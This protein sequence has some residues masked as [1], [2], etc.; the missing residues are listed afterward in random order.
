VHLLQH[1]ERFFSSFLSSKEFYAAFIGAVIGGLLTGRYALRAQKQAAEDQRQRD[2]D[3]ERRAKN[4]TLRAILAELRV[5]KANILDPLDEQLKTQ[6]KKR[7]QAQKNGAPQPPPMAMAHTE[8]NRGTVFESNAGMLGKIDNDK[9]RE[10]IIRVYGLVKGL[11]DQVNNMGSEFRRW[12][13]QDAANPEKKGREDMLEELETRLRTGLKE[14]RCE[15]D[16]VLLKIE[17]Y[18]HP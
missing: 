6:Q 17:G 7:E 9:L 13:A 18:L 3:V 10:K 11:I 4:G 12:R 2:L 15:V 5:I 16:E 8:P 14:L 1:L